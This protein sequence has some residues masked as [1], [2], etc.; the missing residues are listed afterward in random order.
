M[1][2]HIESKFYGFINDVRFTNEELYNAVLETIERIEKYFGE[3]LEDENVT[4]LLLD[5]FSHEYISGANLDDL[6]DEISQSIC[7][8]YDS[9]EDFCKELLESKF[10]IELDF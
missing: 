9:I 4:G 5:L 3:K 8:E 1:K 6:I 2:T 7:L 10:E